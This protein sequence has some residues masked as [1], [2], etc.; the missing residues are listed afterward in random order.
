MAER[1]IDS[2]VPEIRS[3]REMDAPQKARNPLGK[4]L[5]A[6]FEQGARNALD[7]L[8]PRRASSK[9]SPVIGRRV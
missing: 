4:R 7:N 1:K 6:T 3:V 2:G 9:K 8:R 5:I